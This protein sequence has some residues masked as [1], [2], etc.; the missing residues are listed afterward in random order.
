MSQA[1]AIANITCVFNDILYCYSPNLW[2]MAEFFTIHFYNRVVIT[3]RKRSLGQGNIFTPVCH[4]VHRGGGST[5]PADTPLEQ[6]PSGTRY[7][8]PDQV[9]PLEQTPPGP[10]TP[11][12]ADTPPGPGTPP[13]ADTPP[14]DQ[15][16][17]LWSKPP[18]TRYTPQSRHHPPLEQTPPWD[19]VHPPSGPGTPPGL[20]TL[21][22]D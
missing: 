18:R 9:H 11:P 13:G 6:T 1:T 22:W 4:S 14:Q 12:Q 21:P 2:C 10:G 3:A 17:P 16:H 8:P 15:V 20:S 5:W 19:Q 7:T